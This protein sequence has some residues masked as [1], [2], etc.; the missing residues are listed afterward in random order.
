MRS[1]LGALGL[2]LGLVSCATTSRSDRL[3]G[4]EPKLFHGRDGASASWP[5]LVAAASEADVVLIGENHGH[6]LGLE[7]AARLFRDVVARGPKASLSLEFFERDEQ[8]RLDDYLDGL[9][10]L[11][12]FERRTGRTSGN[13][14]PGHHA[15]IEIAKEARRPVHAANAPRAYVR[16]A[17]K[18]GYDRLRAL[19]AEQ[20]RTFFVPLELIG[21]RYREAF[22]EVMTPADDSSAADERSARL[23]A[24]F[25][26][27]Q[28]WDWTMA[29]TLASAGL[30]GEQPVVHVVGRFHTD[31]HG[32]TVQA[33]EKLALGARIVVV[34]F[35]DH[36]ADRER[37]DFVIYVGPSSDV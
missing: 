5:E 3:A 18:E 1:I 13:F 7:S 22:D 30:A 19:T 14:P 27:Q 4:G 20:R 23:D 24:V 12:T 31:F 15:M 6:P 21:G 10:D 32:G 25:R 33:L 28:L 11:A 35:V 2:V 36:E 37:A 9:A 17:R 34:S 8:S 26:S 29:D 16:L